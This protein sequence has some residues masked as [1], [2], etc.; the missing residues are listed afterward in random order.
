MRATLDLHERA[1]LGGILAT[2][3][4]GCILGAMD[5]LAKWLMQEL[6]T[7]QVVWA[8]YFFHTLI[9]GGVFSYRSGIG[10]I[11]TNA[12]LIQM[13][14]AACLLGVTLCL[15]LA[16]RTISLADATAILFFAPVLVT[17]LSGLFLRERVGVQAWM[18]VAVGFAG[19]LFI[20]RPGFRE[21]QP[22]LLLAMLSAVALSFY[23]VLTRALRG[24]DSE[25]TTLFHTTAVGA[26]VLTLLLPIWWVAPS[27]LQW[28]CLVLMGVMG[29]SGHFLLVKA[30]HLAPAPVL[31][32][33]LNAQL[34]ASTLYSVLFFNDRLELG[35]FVGATL[36]VGAGLFVWAHQRLLASRTR[37]RSVTG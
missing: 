7:Q 27:Y 15:Y 1:V 2:L 10:F 33:Y 20:V 11:K 6:P 37:R 12:P 13:V 24:R 17:L 19:V 4:A 25:R 3:V 32:P 21:L 22:A 34:V 28:G 30:F 26:V 5:A 29:A 23:F 14:R 36:I 8:R 18:A 35:F 16:I 9:V 31:S